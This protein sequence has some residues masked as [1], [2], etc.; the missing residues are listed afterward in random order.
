MLPCKAGPKPHLAAQG[1]RGVARLDR[2]DLQMSV[3]VL[4]W[5]SA[6]LAIP[7]V[8][9]TLDPY[10]LTWFRYLPFPI[11]YGAYLLLRRRSTFRQVSG[12]EWPLMA[13]LG[14]LGVVGYHF[15]LNWGLH[16]SDGVQVSG[17]TGSILVATGPLWTLLL[18]VALR[19]ERAT[20]GAVLGSLVAFAGVVVVVFLGKGEAELTVA[21]KS[22]VILLAPICWSVYSVFS[23]PLIERHGGLFVAGVTLS[24]GT[25]TLL[26]LGLTYGAAPLRALRGDQWG[27]LLF[28]ALAC[29]AAGYAIWNTALKHRSAS[30]VA[31]FIYVQPVITAVLGALFF[32][33][34]LTPW[35]LLGSALVLAGV[36][37]VNR[38]R[39]A[40]AAAGA[41][42]RPPIPPIAP[43]GQ[44]GAD[45]ASASSAQ[46]AVP[47]ELLAKP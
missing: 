36:I 8:L 21:A 13:V 5:G 35:F 15:P 20:A 29:T 14:F 41:T 42:S 28:L 19:K 39:L 7:V 3:L 23:K 17:A 12:K 1:G 47:D 32:G 40:A 26:P 2:V 34:T 43:M 16:S 9:E 25:F 22:A 18:A 24:L 6:F 31:A 30:H 10:Q 11:L 37:Q 44:A 45:T 27:W 4:F 38:A 46:A 33:I